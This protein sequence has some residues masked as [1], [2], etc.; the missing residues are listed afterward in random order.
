MIRPAMAGIAALAALA[1]TEP[2]V[3]LS[4]LIVVYGSTIPFS[5]RSFR[6]MQDEDLLA[7]GTAEDIDD[8]PSDDSP[9]DDKP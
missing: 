5:I 7:A 3:A 1:I 8:L 2:W 9:E 4:S 6:K